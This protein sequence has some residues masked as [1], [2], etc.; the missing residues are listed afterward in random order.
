MGSIS[1]VTALARALL[2]DW[3]R[4][5]TG[6]FFSILFPIMLM[7]I[8]TL[9]FSDGDRFEL[10]VQNLDVDGNGTPTRTSSILID[11]LEANDALHVKHIAPDVDVYEYVKQS[12]KRTLVIPK[13][14]DSAMM[15]SSMEARMMVMLSTLDLF[16]EQSS[17]P[18]PDSARSSI[19]SG[20]E[21]LQRGL[22]ALMTNDGDGTDARL[23]LVVDSSRDREYEHVHGMLV[24]ILARVQQKAIDAPDMLD[25]DVIDTSSPLDVNHAGN[26]NYYLPAV[27]AAFIMTNGVVGT[28]EIA[29]D[30]KRRGM[31]KRLMSTPLSR[32]QWIVANMMTQTI[33]ALVLASMM[34]GIA[35]AVFNT[36][37]PNLMSMAVLAIGALCFTGLGMLIAGVLKEPHA[38]AG[39]SNALVF[40]M[41]FLSGTFWPVESMPEYMQSIAY[42]FPLTYFIDA[43]NSSMYSSSMAG[44]LQATSV[45]VLLTGALVLVGSHVTR[46]RQE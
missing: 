45:L 46:W 30:F 44:M 28:S 8:L 37:T 10:Y 17:I 2:L 22:D 41:M 43:L 34:I 35:V 25:M 26:A 40:P 5:K 24:A 29:A 12:S 33:L 38:I 36:S 18:L 4:S 19:I 9:V 39:A 11:V 14:F 16:L 42:I 7:S 15:E 20:R 27:L 31:L 13:G 6:I 3:L 32:L 21:G 1:A 23:L